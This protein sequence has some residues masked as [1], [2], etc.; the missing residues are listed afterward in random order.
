MT[1][2]A[3]NI[4]DVV[5]LLFGGS[6]RAAGEWGCAGGAR[7]GGFRASGGEYVLFLGADDRLCAERGGS[8]STCFAEHPEAGFVVGDI[9]H[10]TLD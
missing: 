8:A 3:S 10:I 1:V 4:G 6:V 9:D 7:N 2:R 5:G